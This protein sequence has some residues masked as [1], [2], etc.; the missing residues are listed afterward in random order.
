[1]VIKKL[2]TKGMHCRSCEKLIEKAVLSI[3]GVKSAKSDYTTE[4]LIVE[5]DDTKTGIDEIAKK[6]NSKGYDCH[7]TTVEPEENRIA[8]TKQVESHKVN[9]E[10]YHFSSKYILIAGSILFL[11]GLVWVINYSYS[12]N[13]PKITPDMGLALIFVV[14]ILTSFH[15]VGMCGGFVLSYTT[16]DAA[17]KNKTKKS[18]FVSHLQYASGKT[19]TY[20]TLGALFGLL[21]SF[22]TFTPQ[23]KGI[24]ALIAG[25]FLIVY[26]LNMINIFPWFRKLQFRGPKFLD[27]INA[28]AS[29]KGPFIIGLLNG[30]MIA[31]GPLQAMLIYAA[32][33]GSAAQ[34]AIAM[35]VF[36]LGTLPLMLGFGSIATILGSKFTHRVLKISAA[37]VIILGIVMLNRG[38]TLMGSGYDFGSL[39]TNVATAGSVYQNQGD[40]HQ[41]TADGYQEIKMEVNSGGYTPNKFILK[42]G[43][44]VKWV[45]DVT[46]LTGC[47]SVI[48]SP[49]LGI[50]QE[51]QKGIQTIEFTPKEEGTIPFSC[52]MGMLRGTFVVQN[53]VGNQQEVQKQLTQVDVP[54]GGSCGGSGC[55]CGGMM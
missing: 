39:A 22:I 42:K 35:L 11:L 49:K 48:Q 24:A 26:G 19:I 15:C 13:L 53:A 32:G 5:F 12:F 14:G 25:L 8:A 40:Y 3:N 17:D 28:D 21:G 51:L 23:L 7:C 38:L 20:V 52:G 47:N 50:S 9:D 33:T 10:Y 6:V 30:L 18:K 46:E 41:L 34:G 43:V 54:K 2:K 16:K 31:C 4:E 44:P 36:G 37:I 29:H 27:K 45:I 1:M 55:G